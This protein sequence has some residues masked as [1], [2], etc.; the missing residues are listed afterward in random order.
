M[1]ITETAFMPFACFEDTLS[2]DAV[3]LAAA[4]FTS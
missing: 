3:W 4:V 2:W 1:M